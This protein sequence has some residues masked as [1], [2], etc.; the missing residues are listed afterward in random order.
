LFFFI[1]IS[2]NE[3]ELW[4]ENDYEEA[5]NA[6]EVT[7]DDEYNLN[8]IDEFKYNANELFDDH[9]INNYSSENENLSENLSE[10]NDLSENENLSGDDNDSVDDNAADILNEEL[11]SD[12][13]LFSDFDNEEGKD[14]IYIIIFSFFI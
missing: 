2:E 8:L 10:D 3:D 7:I 12:D 4:D 11:Y 1:F 14:I 13:E 6:T 9:Q 5:L